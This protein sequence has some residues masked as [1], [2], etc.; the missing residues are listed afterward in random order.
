[1]LQSVL[2]Q[3][4]IS[5]TDTL[6][7]M[8]PFSFTYDIQKAGYPHLLVP[9]SEA[10]H[11]PTSERTESEYPRQSVYNTPKSVRE[12]IVSPLHTPGVYTTPVA[13]ISAIALD[14]SIIV[15]VSDSQKQSIND[16][17]QYVAVHHPSA[18]RRG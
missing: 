9:L 13:F 6:R 16:A 4:T 5:P 1:M 3:S 2:H 14:W 17:F 10:F 7:Q 12:G 8:I 18:Q 15:E 11:S